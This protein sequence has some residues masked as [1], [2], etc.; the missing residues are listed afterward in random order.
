MGPMWDPTWGGM[1]TV[2]ISFISTLIKH[3]LCISD[4]SS[5]EKQMP[6]PTLQMFS[7][8]LHS[9]FLQH[10]LASMR[11][12]RGTIVLILLSVSGEKA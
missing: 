7:S 1:Y 10:G 12:G 5:A 8:N 6:F 3:I 2:E 4:F 11:H 9:Q